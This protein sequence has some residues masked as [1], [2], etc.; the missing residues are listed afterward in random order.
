MKK[1]EIKVGGLYKAKVSNRLTTVRV[2]AIREWGAPSVGTGTRYDVTNLTTGRK[3]TFRSAAKFREEV[4]PKVM[5]D[6]KKNLEG[7]GGQYKSPPVA[8]VEIPLPKLSVAD[9]IREV[10]PVDDAPHLI[11]EA[12]AGT[13]KT[14]T[15]IG[16]IKV[17]LGLEPLDAKGRP[18]TPSPQQQMIWDCLSLSKERVQS[19]AFCA[20]NRSIKAELSARVPAGCRAMTMNG[21]GFGAVMKNFRLMGGDRSVNKWRVDDVIGEIEGRDSRDLMRENP[22]MMTAVHK[23]VDLCRV[24]LTGFRGP[25]LEWDIT[26]EALSQLAD[27]YEVE[28]ESSSQQ[29]RVFDLVPR[30]LRRLLDVNKDGCVDFIDQVWLPVVLDLPMTR[31]DVL[32][33]DEAQDLNKCQQELAKKAGRRL[34]FCGDPRQAIYGF[35]GADALAMSRLEDDLGRT[36]RGCV[37]LYLTVTRRC[38]RAI[39]EE[40]KRLVPD[41]EAHDTNPA[42]LISRMRMKVNGSD[43]LYTQ[44][45]RDGDMVLCRVNAP[46]V[47]EC[48]RFIKQGRKANI[49]GRD[50]GKGLIAL[51]D[52]VTGYHRDSGTRKII[53]CVEFVEALSEW[54]HKEVAK[55]Q[56]KRNPSEG[57]I[58]GI[59]DKADCLRCFTEGVDHVEGVIRKV[60]EVFAEKKCPRCNRSYD[61]DDKVCSNDRCQAAELVLPAGIRLSS[62]HKAKGLEADRVFLLEPKGG[63]VPHPMAK[64]AWQVEQEFN[65][66]YVAITRAIEE[67]V[68]VTE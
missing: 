34:I 38:G 5:A 18:M 2:D 60:N 66:R 55:E 65:L 21:L 14:T 56:A 30:V 50:V 59:Q 35:S 15:L 12:R 28:T 31:Y 41:F 6:S 52:N 19:V 61:V 25:G 32:L 9:R 22:V 53:D 7:F 49:M 47:S 26:D 16:G 29:R 13:G 44:A 33:V 20:F 8:D 23:L 37:K 4:K 48:F 40:A 57:R 17:M 42:G 10:R 62:I 51:V 64:S 63:G 11:V 1:S 3:T 27:H 24:N 68:Y 39:V 43:V 58:I 36:D 45:C 54:E 67:L 46:L